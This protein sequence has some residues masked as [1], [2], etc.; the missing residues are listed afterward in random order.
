MHDN[1]AACGFDRWA[2]NGPDY[3]VLVCR[4]CD[5][6]AQNN[7]MRVGPPNSPGTNNGWFLAPFGDRK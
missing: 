7:G 4:R 5:T 2:L 6:S 1:C 3:T